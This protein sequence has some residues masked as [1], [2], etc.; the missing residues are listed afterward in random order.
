MDAKQRNVVEHVVRSLHAAM[1]GQQREPSVRYLLDS[2]PN[3]SLVDAQIIDEVRS[4]FESLAEHDA[5]PALTWM[6]SVLGRWGDT[7]DAPVVLLYLR[8]IRPWG[9]SLETELAA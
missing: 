2:F 1:I 5:W 9:T 3:P 8:S 6:I 7:M 4:I